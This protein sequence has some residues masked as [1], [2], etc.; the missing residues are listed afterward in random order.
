MKFCACGH[1]LI[2]VQTFRLVSSRLVLHIIANH[3]GKTLL[4]KAMA[5]ECGVNFMSVKGPELLNMYIGESERNVRA[6]FAT[7]RA[8]APCIL[9]FDELDSLAPA[10]GR[11]GDS[12]GVMDRIVSQL[13]AEIDSLHA[14]GGES[15][16]EAGNVDDTLCE[17]ADGA[18]TESRPLYSAYVA[19][20]GSSSAQRRARKPVFVVA[21]TNRPDLL[22]P[23]MLRP[24][25]FDR[26]VYLGIS[27][28][29]EAKR[30]ILTALTRKFKLS[31]DVNLDAV[32][33]ACPP[34]ATG[35]DLYGVA[36]GALSSVLRR[37]VAAAE[38]ALGPA[39]EADG[40]GIIV[41]QSDFLSAAASLTPS[42]SEAELNHYEQLRTRFSASST[43]P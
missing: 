15:A 20:A 13:L 4:A 6:I 34:T 2:V 11:G 31:A 41:T 9:F 43:K 12:A 35:A 40:T 8:S 14:D 24:G 3:A 7:A 33:R 27:R 42:V 38:A 19:R 16:D 36:A 10:R 18:D 17:P 26:L 5:T 1:P 22:D 30:R 32:A 25:R 21:A 29:P 39:C 37:R 28:E 23:A